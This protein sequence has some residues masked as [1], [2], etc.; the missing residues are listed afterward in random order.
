MVL[1]YVLHFLI[2]VAYPAGVCVHPRLLQWDIVTPMEF[3]GLRNIQR[4]INDTTFWTA[5]TNTLKFLVLHIPLQIVLALLIAVVLNGP[6]K[7]RGFFRGAFFLPFVISGA[8]VTILWQ[9]L[10]ST[11]AG[12]FN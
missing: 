10:Y 9:Q 3:I 11:D 12:V 4:L 1:P 6:I 8:V 5:V 7:L 2:F